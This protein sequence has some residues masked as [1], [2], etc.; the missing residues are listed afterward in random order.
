MRGK[1]FNEAKYSEFQN[2]EELTFILMGV[3]GSHGKTLI[4]GKVHALLSQKFV[5]GLVYVG[6]NSRE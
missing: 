4:V 2:G 6:R 3:S 5:D 1:V